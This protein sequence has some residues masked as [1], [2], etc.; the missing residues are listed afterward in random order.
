MKTFFK[1]ALDFFQE[2]SAEDELII[3]LEQVDKE[4]TFLKKII[5]IAKYKKIIFV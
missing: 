1:Q 2:E 3:L 5:S 4:G